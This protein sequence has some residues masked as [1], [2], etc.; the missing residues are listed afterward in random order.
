VTD[1]SEKG[2]HMNK[3]PQVSLAVALFAAM[4]LP[5]AYAAPP[6][7]RITP[8][9]AAAS[10]VKR[11][12]GKVLA[13]KYEFED[14]HWQYAVTIKNKK[15]ELYEAEVSAVTGKVTDTERTT[16]AEEAQEAAADKK[17]ADAKHK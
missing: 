5:A 11:V 1:V 7:A 16:A 14:G 15:G 3:A 6:K 12:P 10:A 8:Q 2:I 4:A 17:K 13:T 9:Q